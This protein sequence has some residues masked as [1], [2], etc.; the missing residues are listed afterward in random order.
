MWVMFAVI[1][2]FMAICMVIMII[3]ARMI[4]V[5][6]V[7]VF[8]ALSVLFV[9][10][11]VMVIV[12]VAMLIFEFNCSYAGGR[13]HHLAS[14]RRRLGKTLQPTLEFKSVYEQHISLCNRSSV[15]WRGLINMRI[16]ARTNERCKRD[17]VT[18]DAFDHVAQYRK[19]CNNGERFVRRGRTGKDH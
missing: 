10:V 1:V 11:I 12:L 18:A 5:V 17:V 16:P 13:D 15:L 2:P 14:E 7:I 3:V 8:F 6:V 4:L 19:C 9:V